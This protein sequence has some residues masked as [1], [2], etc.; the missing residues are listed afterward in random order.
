MNDDDA[1]TAEQRG[2]Y[3]V[4]QCMI[5]EAQ[6]PTTQAEMRAELLRLRQKANRKARHLQVPFEQ[7]HDEL[8]SRM[9]RLTKA[10][11]YP[12]PKGVADPDDD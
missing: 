12:L 6:R 3:H 2:Y 8:G 7:W 5:A 1:T 4:L 9:W 11:G 10:L